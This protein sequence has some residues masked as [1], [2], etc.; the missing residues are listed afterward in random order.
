MKPRSSLIFSILVC[1]SILASAQQNHFLYIQTENK[2]PFY[3][4]FNNTILSSAASG[5]LII[6][7]LQNG[8]F[9]INIGFPKNEWP[10]QLLTFNIYNKDLGVLLKNFNEKGWGF[11]NLVSQQVNIGSQVTESNDKKE[12]EDDSFIN[13][14]SAVVSS[15]DLKNK[16]VEEPP[17]TTPPATKQVS[18]QVE[19]VPALAVLLLNTT[20]NE[21]GQK[22][23]YL[24]GEDTVDVFISNEVIQ[25]VPDLNAVKEEVVTITPE[26][27]EKIIVQQLIDSNIKEGTVITQEQ[28]KPAGLAINS[29][30]RANASEND[31]LKLRKKMASEDKD[32]QMM[33]VAKKA[34][35]S[36]CY[37]TDNVKN[38]SVLFLKDNSRYQFFEL[39]YPFVYDSNNFS[40]L[41]QQLSDPYYI[42]RFK[43]LTAR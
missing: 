37:S 22:F 38:L 20:K 10:S 26:S 7:K 29:D 18:Q 40:N 21:S 15:P 2:Q 13:T 33:S 12:Q 36:K 5:Y 24:V 28:Q 8:D 34:F 23:I 4:N 1:C 35:K 17:N 16:S 25:A 14:L 6:P 39:A 27:Q 32:Y 42:N 11:V 43:A 41:S 30:C 9:K 3:V 31:F 19:T